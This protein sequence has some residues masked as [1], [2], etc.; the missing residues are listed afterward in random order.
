LFSSAL[1]FIVCL[2]ILAELCKI[3]TRWKS[4]KWVRE[5]TVR[6]RWYSGCGYE[7]RNFYWNFTTLGHGHT[8]IRRIT[9]VSVAG[10][11]P[12]LLKG[13]GVLLLYHKDSG[14]DKSSCRVKP[15]VLGTG[16]LQRDSGV[17]AKAA[18]I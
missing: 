2:L 17:G 14:S 11:H 12:R 13:K 6:F 9:R 3:Y 8:P 18:G 4:G 7:S 5:E 16:V 15:V 1:V 10:S